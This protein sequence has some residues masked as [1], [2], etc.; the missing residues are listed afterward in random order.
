MNRSKKR[1]ACLS[2]L[3]LIYTFP[4]WAQLTEGSG[5]FE[6]SAYPGLAGK[7]MRIFYHKPTGEVGDMPILFVMHGVL[8]N[9][10]TYRDNW[11]ELSDTYK[12]LVIVPEFSNELFPG[13]RSYNY[14]NLRS[15]SGTLNDEQHW[16]FSLLDP[17]FDDVVS[18]SGSK[19][20]R[21][22][23]FGHSA[24]SQFVHRFFLFKRHSKAN[25][26][27]AANAGGYTMLDLDVDF[28]YG[29]K[30][31]GFD[32]ERLSHVLGRELIIQLG[33][34]DIDPAHRH[35]NVSAEAMR[36]GRH[37]LERGMTFF[38]SAKELA[39]RL[40]IDFKWNV[41]LV[42]GVAHENEKM[43]VDIAQYLYAH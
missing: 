5:M 34:E 9:A 23:L 39:K 1:N 31:M 3:L 14:G 17:I 12:V 38:S 20:Q 19:Q 18:R 8:R 24:G 40:N 13:S 11:V 22:D 6:F 33:E 42:P 29:L 27:V 37:R 28:P 7:T 30:G 32:T 4:V 26:V 10:E 21:Y 16:S 2:A 25:R 36:Q 41:R 15:S 35:L 43:A